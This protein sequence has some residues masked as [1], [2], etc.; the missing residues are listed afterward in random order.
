[1]HCTQGQLAWL[2]QVEPLIAP[3]DRGA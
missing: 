2:D 1:V 3:A